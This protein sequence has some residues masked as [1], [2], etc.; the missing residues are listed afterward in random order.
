MLGG[1]ERIS[2]SSLDVGLRGASSCNKTGAE[3][4]KG[5][6]ERKEEKGIQSEA[7]QSSSC[8][9]E[10]WEVTGLFLKGKANLS[11]LL[12]GRCSSD[13]SPHTHTHTSPGV[14]SF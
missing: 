2:V 3:K 8:L 9:K 7:R 4:K 11:V 13:V 10:A 14:W 12:K 1:H 5:G 6:G